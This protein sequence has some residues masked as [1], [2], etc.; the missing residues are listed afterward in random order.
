MK[1]WI[2]AGLGAC[3]RAEGLSVLLVSMHAFE[4]QLQQHELLMY[5]CV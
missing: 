3:C 1:Q 5:V 4:W 2:C